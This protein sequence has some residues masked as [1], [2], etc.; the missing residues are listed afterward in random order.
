MVDVSESVKD[1]DIG[2]DDFKK[3]IDWC[4][5]WIILLKTKGKSVIL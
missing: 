2:D 5:I 3:I 1:S 4:D